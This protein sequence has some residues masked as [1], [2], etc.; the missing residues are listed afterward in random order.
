MIPSKSSV[1][2]KILTTLSAATVVL[3]QPEYDFAFAW[4]H[5]QVVT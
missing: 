1:A 4:T 2:P 5:G 3:P